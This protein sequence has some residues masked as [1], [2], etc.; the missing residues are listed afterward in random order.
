MKH[1]TISILLFVLIFSGCKPSSKKQSQE[2][3]VIEYSDKLDTY[4]SALKD[5]KKFNGVVLVQKN[6][7]PIHFKKYNMEDDAESSLQVEKASQF[8]IHSISKLMAKAVLVDL[9]K[10]N[11]LSRSNKVATYIKDF[12]R[13]DE[14]TIQHLLDNQSGLPR[15]LTNPPAN[16]IQKNPKE[17]M[18]LIKAEALLVEP[19]TEAIYSN[20]GY[21]VLYYIMAE[22]VNIPF[23]Q[24]LEERLFEPLNMNSTGA[25]FHLEKNNLSKLVK[26]HEEDDGE[27][28]VVPNIEDDGKNQ[29]K[30]YS[31]VEDLLRFAE[32]VKK[33][34]YLSKIKNRDRNV[35]GWSGGGD[36]ILSHLEHNIEGEYELVFFSNYD[37]IPFG[38]IIKT[39]EKIMS[40]QPYELPQAI[41]RKSKAVSADILNRYEGKYRIREFNNAIFEYRVEDGNLVF[42]Q[43]GERGGVLSAESDSTFFA[44]PTDE[45]YFEFR[46]TENENYKLIF[47]YK[48][49]E[50]EGKKEVE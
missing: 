40:N 19:G 3:A 13:G 10:E 46:S 1:S 36:G 2:T 21:Q 5:L 31:S 15:N 28:V 50:I 45:D 8:D 35:V 39:V 32:H 27:I 11:I 37:E 34:P 22:S 16:L 33:E 14:I 44:L 4:F 41:N 12:P 49:V 42:Y 29:A 38:D 6:D 47:H 20:I 24:L 25:H 17:L 9:E 23:V 43:D 7:V 18:E 48:K 30:I 26:N